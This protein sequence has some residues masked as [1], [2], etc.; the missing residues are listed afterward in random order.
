M[1]KFYE[2]LQ[3]VLQ[4]HKFSPRGIWIVD[5]TEVIIRVLEI[6]TVAIPINAQ[7]CSLPPFFVL[8]VDHF[9]DDFIT[10]LQHF[11]NL[12]QPSCK[13]QRLLILDNH[14]SHISIRCLNF[15]KANYSVKS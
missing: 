12:V 9:E 1:N 3:T 6:V 14:R 5:E 7:G 11:K 8:P 10:L 4:Y 15:C 13:Q 2:D